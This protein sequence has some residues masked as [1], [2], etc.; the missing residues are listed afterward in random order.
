MK[1]DAGIIGGTGIGERL[2][3]MDARPL[4]VPTPA[5]LLRGKLLQSEGKSILLVSRHSAGHK[6]PPHRV[7]YRAMALGLSQLGAKVCF[8]T[9]AVGS[10]RAEWPTGTFV[11]PNDFLDLT[12]RNQTL[13]ERTVVHT[14]FTEAF[15]PKART[16][17]LGAAAGEGVEAKDGG[18]YVCG[19]G[20]RYETPH[21]I[22]LMGKVGDLVGMTAS[23]EAIL[24]R[25]AGIDYGCLSIVTNL[26][27]GLSD[28]P[29][30]H[31]EVVEEMERAGETAVRILLRA[32]AE[33]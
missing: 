21:E 27:A 29:L 18:V 11:V 26:A 31:E 7:N 8:S 12:F 15:G 22:Q 33:A 1:I 10:L 2:A 28:F 17:L 5:G 23:T 25:E 6:V 24:M 30:S 9:A 3:Q 14:D 4:H 13:F 19:N 20:P 32:V 16:A